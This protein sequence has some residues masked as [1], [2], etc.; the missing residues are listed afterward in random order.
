MTPTD[1][2]SRY[3]TYIKPVINSGVVKQY[4]AWSLTIVTM[5]IFIIFAIKPTVETISVLQQKLENSN[6]TLTQVNQKLQNLQTGR[7]NYEA[8]GAN[9]LNKINLAVPTQISLNTLIQPLELAARANQASISALQV[10]PVI[11]T[12]KDPNSNNFT[13][14]KVQFTFNTEGS[15]TNIMRLLQDLE[16]SERLISIDSVVLNKAPDSSTILMSVVGKAYYL[17]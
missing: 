11:I 10:D 15:F 12:Q 8:L 2:Y 14:E 6:Q 16:Q 13:L 9:T 3:Y 5:I 17:K 7:K 4:G 1:R